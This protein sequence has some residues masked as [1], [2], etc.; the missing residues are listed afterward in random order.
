MTGPGARRWLASGAATWG[1]ERV[2][3][4]EPAWPAWKAGALP[5]S[6]TRV[7]RGGS[8]ESRA[9]PRIL[10]GVADSL[11]EEVGPSFFDSLVDACYEGV[12]RDEILRPMYPEELADAK[13]H[14]TLFLVQYWGGPPT[15]SHECQWPIESPRWWPRKV[16]TLRV[17]L[18]SP[19]SRTGLPSL[20]TPSFETT[21]RW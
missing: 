5:L 10:R 1:V 11:Y 16:P 2:T 4:I 8:I 9:R 20:E 17:I 19:V 13:R 7:P 14:L 18:T 21:R 6:Y 12:A 15:Y 3:G